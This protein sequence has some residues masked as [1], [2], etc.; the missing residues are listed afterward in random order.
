LIT[1]EKVEFLTVGA[2]YGMKDATKRIASQTPAICPGNTMQGGYKP[3]LLVLLLQSAPRK[4]CFPNTPPL[5]QNHISGTE[6]NPRKI[7]KS[8]KKVAS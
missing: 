6:F 5:V 3:L 7:S 1:N 8:F 4:K 2:T